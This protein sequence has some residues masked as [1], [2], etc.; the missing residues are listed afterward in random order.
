LLLSTQT[1]IAAGMTRCW[2]SPQVSLEGMMTDWCQLIRA[3]YREMPGLN[4]TAPQVRRL[5]A[6]DDITCE[7]V[8]DTLVLAKVLRRTKAG[9]YV[10]ADASV[11]EHTD[12]SPRA[13]DTRRQDLSSRHDPG[14][15]DVGDVGRELRRAVGGGR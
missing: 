6:L 11:W 4:L 12:E 3:E 2:L 7:A 9:T 5:W 1:T 10:K 8:L 14:R 13:N 15:G